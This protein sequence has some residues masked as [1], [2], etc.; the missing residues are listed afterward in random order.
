MDTIQTKIGLNNED[1][2]FFPYLFSM[3]RV[4]YGISILYYNSE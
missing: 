4:I 2:G 3:F 1:K